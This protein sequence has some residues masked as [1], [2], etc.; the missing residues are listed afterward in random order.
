MKR[1]LSAGLSIICDG[2]DC[3]A[4]LHI[5]AKDQFRV[6]EVLAE[7]RWSAEGERHLCTVCKTI[8]IH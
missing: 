6:P 7:Q 8:R 2:D 4:A 1:P 5:E 3:S